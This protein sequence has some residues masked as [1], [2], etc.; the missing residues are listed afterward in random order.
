MTILIQVVIYDLM[1]ILI[2][3]VIFFRLK[4]RNIMMTTMNIAMVPSIDTFHQ[5]YDILGQFLQKS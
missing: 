4:L 5:K 1:T 2:Q 3:V